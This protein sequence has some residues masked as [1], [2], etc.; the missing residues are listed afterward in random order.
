ML[1]VGI[2]GGIGSGKST[3]LELFRSA[4]LNV[5]DA[6]T[7][8]HQLYKNNSVITEQLTQRWGDCILDE[9]NSINRAAVA[10]IVF[11][12]QSELNWL[13]SVFHP[14][15]RQ[16]IKYEAEKSEKG[17]WCAVP[18]LYEVG[19]Q[20][21]FNEII[22]IWCDHKTQ[23]ERLEKRAWSEM[24]I[25]QRLSSQ[26]SMDLKLQK[27]DYGIINV[28]NLETLKKQCESVKETILNKYNL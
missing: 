22:S 20:Q 23:I 27:A 7:V 4:G 11:K 9:N 26:M 1:V 19:W 14:Q 8:V 2:T 28:S 21:D 17:L 10:E 24:H 13:N 15:V 5:L 16:I 3:V 18:L 12:D 25:K 6:D